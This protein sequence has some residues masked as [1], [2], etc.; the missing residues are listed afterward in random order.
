MTVDDPAALLGAAG[1]DLAKQLEATEEVASQR[2]LFAVPDGVAYL[3]GNSLGLQP[4]AVRAALDDVLD[5]WATLGVDGHVEGP[6]PWM[7]YHE[8]MRDTVARLVGARPGEAVVMNSLTVNL[9]LLMGSFYRPTPARHRIVIEA[10]VFPSDRYA[11]MSAARAHGYDPQ[12]AVV[13]LTPRAGERHLHTED[14]RAFLEREGTSVAIVALSAVDFRSGALLDIPTITEAAHRAGA[15]AAWDLAHAAGNVPLHLHEWDVDV[16]VWCHYKYVNAG[17]GAV[18]GCFVHE[19]HGSDPSLVRP[20]GWWGH[21]P[22]SRFDMPFAFAPQPGAEGWQ[23]SNPPIL[24]MAPV[25]VSLEMFDRVGLD[26]LRG[27]SIRLTGFLER[28]LDAVAARRELEIVT[29]RAPSRRGAQLSVEV[30]NPRRVN[31]ALFERHRVRCDDR[32][33]NIIR[34]APAPLYNTF[35]DCWRA[36]VALDAELATV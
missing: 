3:A 2:H 35:N 11:L 24:A 14:I 8:T 15:L 6:Y 12:E 26:A 25:R 22:A 21:D 18:G 16:A 28:L 30:D 20:G 5:A 13:I 23:V 36:A 1:E 17:P 10:D 4:L 19:R 32:P 33:P 27:R 29:P 7:P 9:H 31:D 34:I